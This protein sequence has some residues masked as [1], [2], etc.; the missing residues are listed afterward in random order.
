M[1]LF[2]HDLVDLTSVERI[3]F[4]VTAILASTCS[5]FDHQAAKIRRNCKTSFRNEFPSFG[6]CQSYRVLNLQV[7]I[8]LR[9]FFRGKLGSLFTGDQVSHAVF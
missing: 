3:E 8:E 6:L 5:A 2:G 9:A 4:S 7:V 1:V